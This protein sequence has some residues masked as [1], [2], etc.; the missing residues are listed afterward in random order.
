MNALTM[1]FC[2]W[3]TAAFCAVVFIRGATR[4]VAQPEDNEQRDTPRHAGLFVIHYRN[5]KLDAPGR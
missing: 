4:P 3:A 1:F 2:I 5:T